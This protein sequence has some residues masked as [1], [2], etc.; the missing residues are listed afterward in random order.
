MIMSLV[1]SACNVGSATTPNEDG[2]VTWKLNHIRPAGTR[3]D[4]SATKFSEDIYEGTDG[5]VRSEERRVGKEC[6]SRRSAER[7][8]K[9]TANRQHRDKI[10]ITRDAN[11]SG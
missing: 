1:L 6:R 10:R 7:G 4:D 8:N 2:E 5:R 11:S 3:T 9:T